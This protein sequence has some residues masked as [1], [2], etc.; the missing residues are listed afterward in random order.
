ENFSG[1]GI[2]PSL[3]Q[4]LSQRGLKTP[5]PIQ[6][7]SIPAGLAGQDVVGIA[8][9]GTGKTLAFGIPMMQRLAQVKGRGL[10][11]VP[12][13]ELA[14]QVDESLHKIGRGIGLRSAVLIGGASMYLQN[15]ALSKKPHVI[16]ATPGRL[17]DHL[18]QKTIHLSDVKILVLDEADRMLDMGFA[19]Q[20][21]RILAVVPRQRQTMLFSATMPSAIMSMASKHMQKPTRVEVAPSGTTADR[22]I[23]EVF[24]VDKGEK[25]RLLESLLTQYHGTV[26]VFSRTKHG[27]KRIARAVR[28]MGQTAAEIHSNR[29]LSQ[30]REALDG[31]KSGRYRVLVATDIA[32]RGIDVVGIELVINYDLPS[33]SEDYVHRIGRTGRAG[34][35]GRAISFATPDQRRDVMAIER[36]IRGSLP[37]S[38]VP[39][40]PPARRD[41]REVPMAQLPSSEGRYSRLQR[42][43]SHRRPPRRHQGFR[44]QL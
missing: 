4:A 44:S 15:Q 43:R 24:F 14:L 40:L 8:Q 2:A 7:Q 5:T 41:A 1:L 31:F 27:A 23:Q 36:V 38:R 21:N 17:L 6:A 30:R 35:A 12:T 22:V 39:H 19:P 25:N 13:R 16:V 11:I 20:I 32:A 37:V 42:R 9:T 29:S 18:E 34:L 3:L 28:T 26:L 10:I 33:Q